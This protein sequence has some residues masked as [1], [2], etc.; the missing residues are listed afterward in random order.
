MS[1]LHLFFTTLAGFWSSGTTLGDEC[2]LGKSARRGIQN[3]LEQL[4]LLSSF[5]P[6]FLLSLF[7]SSGLFSY[8]F[9]LP[10]SSVC[11]L[12]I[13]SIFASFRLVSFPVS[14]FPS[15]FRSVL[16]SVLPSFSHLFLLKFSLCSRHSFSFLVFLVHCFF[17][18]YLLACVF[19][20]CFFP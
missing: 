1:F 9:I 11:Y 6:S 3:H 16:V 4:S 15:A 17:F 12:G 20:T 13:L 14:L 19:D 5:L 8:C 18:L 10:S 2:F 7:H